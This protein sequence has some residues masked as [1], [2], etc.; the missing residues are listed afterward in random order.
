MNKL[1]EHHIKYKEIHGVDETVWMTQ[2]DH[3]KL[4]YRLRREGN[5][6]IPP[7]ELRKI[8]GKAQKRTE[9]TRKRIKKYNHTD[10]ARKVKKE[11]Y[12]QNYQELV[13]TETM[14]PYILF[15]E[16]IR[17]NHK[18]GYVSYYARFYTTKGFKIP[19]IDIE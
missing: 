17:Y 5:C 8:S 19:I 6:N 1:V 3:L 11:Y 13:F 2:S 16:K 14:L 12:N 10:R 15:I 18:T 4:H 9:K 7:D